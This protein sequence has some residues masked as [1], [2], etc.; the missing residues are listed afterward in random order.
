MK[1]LHSKNHLEMILFFISSIKFFH[2]VAKKFFVILRIVL[3]DCFHDESLISPNRPSDSY[4]IL[5]RISSIRNQIV[6]IEKY[7]I[8]VF[9]RQH[10]FLHRLFRVVVHTP[11]CVFHEEYIS[12]LHRFGE[13]RLL[14]SRILGAS[15]VLFKSFF[16]TQCAK[17]SVAHP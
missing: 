2:I 16:R 13:K 9:G 3:I 11:P 15:R 17:C 7:I 4:A 14:F 1:P 6:I 8:T 10:S 5:Y 12:P